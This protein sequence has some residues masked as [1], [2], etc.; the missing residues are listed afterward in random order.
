ML[1]RDHQLEA[2][3]YGTCRRRGGAHNGARGFAHLTLFHPV[4]FFSTTLCTMCT[5]YIVHSVH[6]VHILHRIH[7]VLQCT[8]YIA[9]S[10]YQYI[11]YRLH[12]SPQYILCVLQFTQITLLD[13]IYFVLVYFVQVALIHSV[14]NIMCIAFCTSF[15]AHTGYIL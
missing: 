10:T 3:P 4:H 7:Y 11:V 15:I 1:N 2:S 9:C 5:A 13:S 6:F 8:L 12:C 14:H